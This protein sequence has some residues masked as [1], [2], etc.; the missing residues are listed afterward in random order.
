MGCN[1][2]IDSD[3]CRIRSQIDSILAATFNFAEGHLLLLGI[4][5]HAA[6]IYIPQNKAKSSSILILPPTHVWSGGASS[7]HMSS[8]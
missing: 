2:L 7:S 5:V 4:L 8:L 6:A 1:R 3:L